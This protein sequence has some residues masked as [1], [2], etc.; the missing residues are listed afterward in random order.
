MY[1]FRHLNIISF[2][3]ENVKIDSRMRI[4]DRALKLFPFEFTNEDLSHKNS[5]ANIA[6]SKNAEFLMF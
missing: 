5:T 4:L 3:F 1:R 6:M 2:P